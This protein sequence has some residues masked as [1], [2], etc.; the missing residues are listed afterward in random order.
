M[1]DLGPE[2]TFMF[3]FGFIRDAITV[4]QSTLNL[5]TIKDLACD[6]LNSK[7][8]NRILMY[9]LLVSCVLGSRSWNQQVGRP[10]VAVQARV[11]LQQHPAVYQLSFGH[12][13]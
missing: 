4:P 7:V 6:F 13:R 9:P 2:V 11:Q 1:D 10:T 8:S 3:Q 5:K 12:C